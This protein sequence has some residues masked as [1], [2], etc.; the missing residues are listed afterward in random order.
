MKQ[1]KLDAKNLGLFLLCILC[2]GAI[3]CNGILDRFTPTDLPKPAAEYVGAQRNPLGLT[4]LH[5]AKELRNDAIITHRDTQTELRRQAEDD[6]YDYDNALRYIDSAIAEAELLQGV[7]VGEPGNPMS[8][9]GVLAM[10]A[11]GLAIG[12][13]LKRK[14]DKSPEEVEI[15]VARRTNGGG[16]NAH[17]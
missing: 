5:S 7:V 2:V 11:P 17:S 6:K 3:G 16:T 10:F 9:A 12:R 15:E 14:G 4:T 1:R 13:M 8:I